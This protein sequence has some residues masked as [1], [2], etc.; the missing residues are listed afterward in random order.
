[1][2]QSIFNAE[3]FENTQVTEATSTERIYADENEYPAVIDK[4]EF[5]PGTS[6]D[7]RP[8][9]FVDVHWS[10]DSPEQRARMQREKVIVRQSF[11]LQQ[12]EQ[13]GLATGKGIN[14]ELGLLRDA[15]GQNQNGM[16]WTFKQLLGQ[17]AKVK[18]K[19]R[20]FV[21]NTGEPGK[22]AEVVAVTKL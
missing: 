2:A 3:Q 6:K 10:L 22:N 16:P 17:V 19:H 14:V 9:L 7:G 21:T 12:T 20:D 13:G 1:M 11:G 5:R 18:V 8:Y 15:V 4:Y